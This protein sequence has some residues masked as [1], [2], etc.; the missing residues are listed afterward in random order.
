MIRTRQSANF[1][2]TAAMGTSVLNKLWCVLTNFYRRHSWLSSF[3]IQIYLLTETKEF[4]YIFIKTLQII[5]KEHHRWELAQK[6]VIMCFDKKKLDLTPDFQVSKSQTIYRRKLEDLSTIS[7]RF[8]YL[9]TNSANH[10]WRTPEMEAGQRQIVQ[11]RHLHSLWQNGSHVW[12]NRHRFVPWLQ[13]DFLL[14]LSRHRLQKNVSI[15]QVFLVYFLN[16]NLNR[17]KLI[18]EFCVFYTHKSRSAL[19]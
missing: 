2:K 18:V 14:F 1:G 16:L 17:P 15:W 4:R 9:H 11:R 10:F 6:I 13:E 19:S 5:F 7:L 8:T 12:H 3:N